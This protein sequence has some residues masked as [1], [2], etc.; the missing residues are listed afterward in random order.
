MPSADFMVIEQFESLAKDLEMNQMIDSTNHY[1]RR[2]N[3]EEDCTPF[4]TDIKEEPDYFYSDEMCQPNP[5]QGD[6]DFNT[7]TDQFS[8]HF[9]KYIP[10]VAMSAAYSTPPTTTAAAPSPAHQCAPVATKTFSGLAASG[11]TVYSH[12][13][14]SPAPAGLYESKNFLDL[15]N[16]T[17]ADLFCDGFESFIKHR[18]ADLD[19]NETCQLLDDFFSELSKMGLPHEPTKWSSENVRTW[20][21]WICHKNHKPDISGKCNM[22]GPLLC[23]LDTGALVKIFGELGEYIS[24]EI[25]LVKSA[26]SVP[27]NDFLSLQENI[28]VMSREQMPDPCLERSQNFHCVSPAPSTT[29]SHDSMSTLSNNSE[30]ESGYGS[31][32]RKTIPI[33]TNHEQYTRSPVKVSSGRGHKQKIHLWQFLKELLLSNENHSDCIRW[34][35]RK[36]G[37]FKIEDSKKVATLWG[38]RKNRP[39]MNYDKLSRSVRQYYKKGIIKKTEQ[40]KRLVYQFCAGYL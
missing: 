22:N 10:T 4:R 13:E 36:A 7:I 15:D 16:Q 12:P 28:G 9:L 23:S 3:A 8:D 5:T 1:P 17:Q 34:L 21:S 18:S 20:L 30:D 31:H 32:Y 37:I 24:H 35:D 27:S 25:D 38:T 40:S 29:S 14:Y 39:A 26:S 6:L 19:M 2:M 33:L 11:C